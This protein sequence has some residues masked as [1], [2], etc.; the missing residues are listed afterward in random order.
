MELSEILSKCD[1]TLLSQTATWEQIKGI[2]DDGMKYKTASVCIPAAH[3]KQAKEYVG[4]RLAI[5]TVIGF[6]NGYDTTAAKCFMA[7]DAVANG[8]DEVDMVVNLGD[9]FAML[10]RDI[11]ITN[12][13]LENR[14]ND[15]LT[16][17]YEATKLPLVC[18]NGNHDGIWFGFHIQQT[19]FH[20]LR[21]CFCAAS[22][23]QN[24][25]HQMLE[26]Q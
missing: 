4:N 10:G 8:A 11:H 1:H 13:E 19:V 21:F 15:L 12:A 3:V 23:Q 16:A 20:R 26:H 14:F 17:M 22:G 24:Q 9:N 25:H 7:M 2:C 18:V 5:C 6:P